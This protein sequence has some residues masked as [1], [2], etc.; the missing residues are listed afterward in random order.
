LEKATAAFLIARA[1]NATISVMQSF[2]VTPFIGQ[3]SL[4]EVLDPIN[5]L[6]EN[7]SWIMLAVIVSIGLQ[8][9]LMEVG[10]TVNLSW[11]LL[12]ALV[13]ILISLFTSA[14]QSKYRLR[15]LAY[16]LLLFTLLVR[17]AIP[18][19]GLVGS[20]ISNAFLAEKRDTAMQSIQKSKEKIGDISISDAATSPKKV[21]EQIQKDSQE[22]VAQIIKLI[23]LFSFETI[24]FPI[25]VLWGLVKIFGVVFYWPLTKSE[26]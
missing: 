19:T 4:G 13:F 1:L 26:S 25:L 2:T 10:I 17:F 21:L 22:I 5:D 24:L 9:L 16:K 23:T 20:Y 8:Q 6:I 11:L 14:G 12:P 15:M 3:L 18:V 7:F